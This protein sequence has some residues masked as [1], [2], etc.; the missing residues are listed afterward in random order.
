MCL[1]CVVGDLTGASL[2]KQP[3]QASW[4]VKLGSRPYQYHSE[5]YPLPT[6]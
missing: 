2:Y 1:L 3:V 4:N 5:P 6:L